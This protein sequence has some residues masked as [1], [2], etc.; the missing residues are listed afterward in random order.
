MSEP[1][2]HAEIEDVLSSIRRLVSETGRSDAGAAAPR[3]S[4]QPTTRLVLTPAL[5]VPDAEITPAEPKQA[6]DLSHSETAP[7][8]KKCQAADAPELSTPEAPHVLVEP[9]ADTMPNTVVDVAAELAS[10]MKLRSVPTVDAEEAPTT[11][12]LDVAP[13]AGEEP[14]NL[15]SLAEEDAAQ[16]PALD[17]EAPWRDPNATL[18]DAAGVAPT[19]PATSASKPTLSDDKA[20]RAPREQSAR[21]AAVVR[22]IAE[23]ETEGNAN[24]SSVPELNEDDIDAVPFSGPTVETIQWEDHVDLSSGSEAAPEAAKLADPE[25]DLTEARHVAQAA[26]EEAAMEAVS[27]APEDF[28]DEQ[29]LR[30]L[31][32]DI[33]REELQGALGERIT[34]NVR[35]LVRREIQRALS[36]QDLL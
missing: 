19:T 33:V 35:K 20:P 6:E 25:S 36:A 1:V 12:A 34:R 27:K 13:D 23:L 17:P 15:A 8:A 18:Y 30:E 22:R 5:R 26:T 14:E 24:G 32:A 11:D 10:R 31:V 9:S 2:T 29:S 16:A 4:A 3:V 28:L 7:E 21:V